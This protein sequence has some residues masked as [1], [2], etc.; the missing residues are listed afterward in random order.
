M[1]RPKTKA[2]I[3]LKNGVV[4]SV[5]DF[6][7]LVKLLKTLN[8]QP[9]PLPPEGGERLWGAVNPPER[10]Q[11]L[12]EWVQGNPWVEHLAKRSLAGETG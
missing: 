7:T 4:I 5:Y 8:L 1:P 10:V 2:K 3:R 12:P 9:K 6:E 11:G